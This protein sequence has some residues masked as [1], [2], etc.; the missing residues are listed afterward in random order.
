M[1]LAEQILRSLAGS[2]TD[3]DDHWLGRHHLEQS[4]EEVGGIRGPRPVVDL[5]GFIE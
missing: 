1:P 3:L 4:V 2:R 5:R